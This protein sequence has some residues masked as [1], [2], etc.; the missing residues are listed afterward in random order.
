MIR[1]PRR[2]AH[3]VLAVALAFG[4]ALLGAPAQAA[5]RAPAQHSISTDGQEPDGRVP[6]PLR[7]GTEGVYAPFSVKEGDEFTGFDIEVMNAVGERLGVEV[8]YVAT[9]WDSMFAALG[10]NRFDVVANQVTYNEEREQLYDLSDPY[11]DTGGVLVVA[12]D[13]PEDIQT[14]EDLKGKRAAENITSSWAEIAEELSAMTGE[15]ATERAV[16]VA[17]ARVRSVMEQ[18]ELIQTVYKRGYRLAVPDESV[19]HLA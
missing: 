14:L 5:E 2:L 4:P 16:E 13:N 15:D 12:E 6:D 8:E 11:V 7:V 1:L 10:S 17:V 3:L 9:P 18:P 19:R